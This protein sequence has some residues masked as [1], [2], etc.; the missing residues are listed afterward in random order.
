MGWTFPIYVYIYIY[1]FNYVYII[2][3]EFRPQHTCLDL[4]FGDFFTECTK[5]VRDSSPKRNN[6]WENM[7]R[8]LF[9][10]SCTN[11]SNAVSFEVSTYEHNKNWFREFWE[12][13]GAFLDTGLCAF[14]NLSNN[15]KSSKAPNFTIRSA[16]VLP[17]E[18]AEASHW[19]I[20]WISRIH[21][22]RIFPFC[23]TGILV[24][25]PWKNH[26][27][28]TKNIIWNRDL[29]LGLGGDDVVFC[30]YFYI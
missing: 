6:I 20:G 29:F 24:E 4:C 12:T 19:S 5:L 23:P 9:Q 7:F 27:Q 25:M 3:R 18:A 16:P 8:N 22:A 10:A 28:K 26:L 14:Q 2:Y 21:T 30:K 1:I 17:C 15:Q 11:K 13:H